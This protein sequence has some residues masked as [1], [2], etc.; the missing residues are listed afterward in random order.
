M[1]HLKTY[2]GNIVSN[3]VYWILPTNNKLEDG[4]VKLYKDYTEWETPVQPI[5]EALTIANYIRNTTHLIR[6]NFILIALELSYD[7]LK[8]RVVKEPVFKPWPY[9]YEKI[10]KED[11]YIFIGLVNVEKYEIDAANYNL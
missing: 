5:G 3:K 2:E 4:L 11:G 7:Y 6:E 9:S 8:D 1:K 10:L